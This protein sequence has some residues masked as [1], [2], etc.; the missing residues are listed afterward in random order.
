MTVAKNVST[1]DRTPPQLAAN[2][3]MSHPSAI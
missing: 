3:K 1:V 2:P